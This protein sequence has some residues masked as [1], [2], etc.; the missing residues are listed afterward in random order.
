[1]HLVLLPGLDGTGLLFSRFVSALGPSFETTVVR[2]PDDQG[3]NYAE[4][5]AIARASLPRDRPYILLGESFSGPIAI[6]IAASKPPGLMGLILCCTFARNP[7]HLYA[8]F[9]SFLGLVPFNVIPKIFQTPFLLGR[10]STRSLRTEHRLAVSRVSNEA[11][12]SRIRAIIEVDVSEKLQR[13]TVPVLYLRASDDYVIPR[14][15]SEHIHRIA[16]GVQIVELKAPHMLLQVLPPTAAK[17]VTV[18][19]SSLAGA[20]DR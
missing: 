3:L 4:H 18:F 12:R 8:H 2:Y 13:I 1:M 5:E 11:L 6:S 16:P 14:R 17:V 10:F 19:A 9:K 20:R 7:L 15:A